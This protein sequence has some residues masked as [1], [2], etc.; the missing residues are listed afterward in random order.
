MAKDHPDYFGT[1][2]HKKQGGATEDGGTTVVAP[3]GAEVLVTVS[4]KGVVHNMTLYCDGTDSQ[5]TSTVTVSI[6][7]NIISSRTINSIHKNTGPHPVIGE[8]A[9]Q[10]VDEILFTYAAIMQ[11]P[12]S[13]ESAVVIS[14]TNNGAAN[15][16]ADGY[17]TY[18]LIE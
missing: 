16:N 14:F 8:W 1:P 6:D 3:A 15:V 10:R 2:V 5:A 4:G 7:G 9:I 11:G 17:V 18:S 12:I 13:F